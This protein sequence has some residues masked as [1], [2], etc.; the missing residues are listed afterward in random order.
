M[1]RGRYEVRDW[2][3]YNRALKN[4]YSFTLWFNTGS[5]IAATRRSP[6]TFSTASRMSFRAT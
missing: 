3:E 1:K 5:D 2:R 6:V 4:R